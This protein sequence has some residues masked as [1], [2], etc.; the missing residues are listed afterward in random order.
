[1]ANPGERDRSS[2]ELEHRWIR[3]EQN[4]TGEKLCKPA[5]SVNLY[6]PI[7]LSSA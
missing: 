7:Q 3:I 1:M 6:H 5:L 2:F 4:F